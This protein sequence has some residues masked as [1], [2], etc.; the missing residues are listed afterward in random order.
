MVCYVWSRELLIYYV[1]FCFRKQ[2]GFYLDF[3]CMKFPLRQLYTHNHKT[4]NS[5]ARY[6]VMIVMKTFKFHIN[7]SITLNAH[8]NIHYS[9]FEIVWKIHVRTVRLNIRYLIPSKTRNGTSKFLVSIRIEIHVFSMRE[10]RNFNTVRFFS[11]LLHSI[12]LKRTVNHTVHCTNEK[13]SYK[14][15]VWESCNFLTNIV[16]CNVYINY[17]LWQNANMQYTVYTYAKHVYS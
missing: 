3:T 5:K 10:N 12:S 6:Y 4:R 2:F 14:R 17:R 9:L 11:S 13:W 8:C 16:N 15:Y 7:G 1:F